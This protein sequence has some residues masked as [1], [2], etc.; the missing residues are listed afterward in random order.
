MEFLVIV[1]ILLLCS[2]FIATLFRIG[3]TIIAAI[4]LWMLGIGSI[5]IVAANLKILVILF[6]ICIA[7]SPFLKACLKPRDK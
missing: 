6:L 1:F 3:T 5:V 2:L 4:N 7:I